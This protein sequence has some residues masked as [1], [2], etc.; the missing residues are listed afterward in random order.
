MQ[1]WKLEHEEDVI[2]PSNKNFAFVQSYW[3]GTLCSLVP[4]CFML[5]SLLS[6]RMAQVILAN[7]VIMFMQMSNDPRR[8]PR[9][10]PP[11]KA[12]VAYGF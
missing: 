11:L 9:P 4:W 10:C 6:L 7:L 12:P 5:A 8:F 2:M 1:L 3:F